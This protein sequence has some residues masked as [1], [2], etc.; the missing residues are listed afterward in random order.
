MK[1]EFQKQNKNDSPKHEHF[2]AHVLPEAPIPLGFWQLLLQGSP[3][4][5]HD[6]RHF[7]LRILEIHKSTLQLIQD[8]IPGLKQMRGLARQSSAPQ[9]SKPEKW[10]KLGRKTFPQKQCMNFGKLP[11]KSSPIRLINPSIYPTCFLPSTFKC[12]KRFFP[13]KNPGRSHVAPQKSRHREK[14]SQL[15][16]RLEPESG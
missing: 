14:R 16:G 2:V 13:S 1:S 10:F 6:K 11:Q 3:L 8:F 4:L 5:Q 9:H 15:T 7:R 12:H